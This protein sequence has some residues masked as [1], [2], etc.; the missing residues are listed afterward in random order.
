[1]MVVQR[2]HDA[3][4]CRFHE[5]EFLM[6]ILVFFMVFTTIFLLNIFLAVVSTAYS[7]MIRST[8]LDRSEQVHP[9]CMSLRLCHCLC[10]SVCH[11][12]CVSTVDV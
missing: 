10:V 1:M 4:G 12:V 3:A 7:E 5:N 2:V 9:D 8:V 11:S 6:F